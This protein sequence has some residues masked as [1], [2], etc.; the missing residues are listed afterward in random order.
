MPIS[1]SHLTSSWITGPCILLVNLMKVWNMK[2]GN[3]HSVQDGVGGSSG[4][5]GGDGDGGCENYVHCAMLGDG[6]VGKTCLTLSYTQKLF[7]D[8]Y[9]A[10]VF[11]NYSGEFRTEFSYYLLYCAGVRYTPLILS[12]VNHELATGYRRALLCIKV[13]IVYYDYD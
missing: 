7:T 13:I 12:P 2:S 11:D 3:A 5:G 1:H 10:T 4:S 8:H 6:M 9:T